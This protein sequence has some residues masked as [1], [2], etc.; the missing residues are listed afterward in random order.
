MCV[1]CGFEFVCC[2]VF[3]CDMRACVC[4]CVCFC[5]RVWYMVLSVSGR[6]G[7]GVPVE[8]KGAVVCVYVC[9]CVCVCVCVCV[10]V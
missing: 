9:M 5:D 3:V 4:V 1:V 10:S 8:S 2:F 6:Y 7:G